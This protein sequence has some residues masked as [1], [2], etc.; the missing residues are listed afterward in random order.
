MAW[1]SGRVDSMSTTDV[2]YGGPPLAAGGRYRW[3]V[4][5][6]DETGLASDRSV[7]A[8]PR[9]SSRRATGSSSRPGVP[10]NALD[11]DPATGLML[12]TFIVEVGQPIATFTD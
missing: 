7:P 11:L 9:S 4:R 2:A 3:K 6:W 12:S 5:V 8:G 1:D 10:Q